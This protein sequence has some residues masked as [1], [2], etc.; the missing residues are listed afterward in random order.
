M[1]LKID[2]VAIA[3][4]LANA[5]V[6]KSDLKEQKLKDELFIV[7]YDK[8][9]DTLIDNGELQED[10]EKTFVTVQDVFDKYNCTL[11]QA[12]SVI[13]DMQHHKFLRGQ[14]ELCLK[15]CAN[16]LDLNRASISKQDFIENNLPNYTSSDEVARMNDYY[17][18]ASGDLPRGDIFLI[19][20]KIFQR[21]VQ[22]FPDIAEKRLREYLDRII[23]EN[24]DNIEHKLYLL[25]CE[26]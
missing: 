18:V 17:A 3:T 10:F 12:K 26:K 20:E 25:A 13:E 16:K 8:Y 23:L 6:E 21:M 5:E 4:L 24:A 22:I 1:V 15:S 2:P 11:E 7:A 9:F 19:S 14:I